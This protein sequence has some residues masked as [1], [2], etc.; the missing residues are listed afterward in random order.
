M[1]I[2]LLGATGAMGQALYPILNVRNHQ[3]FVTT[4]QK[5]P[6]FENVHFLEG[7]AFDLNF[8]KPLL[9][10]NKWDAVVDFM[11]YGSDDFKNRVSMFLENTAHYFFLSS[12][13]VYADVPDGII[14]DSP[15][16]LDASNDADFLKTDEY[17]LAKARSENV[18]KNSARQ[19]FTIIR[20]YITFSPY[21]LQL[22]ILEKESWLYRAMQGRT[23]I[24]CQDF[25]N[26]TTTMT[27][28]EIVAKIIAYLIE[29]SEKSIGQTFH[30][31][32]ENHATWQEILGIYQE[33][34][35]KNGV[36][37]KT[38][39]LALADFL[40]LHPWNRYQI[41]YD[42]MFCRAF[43][44]PKLFEVLDEEHRALLQ[45]PSLKKDLENALSLFLK[46]PRFLYT[47]WG[48]EGKKDHITSQLAKRKEFPNTNAYKS[49][50]KARFPLLQFCANKKHA[51]F[52]RLKHFSKG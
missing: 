14:E 41:L 29:H 28:G 11:V 25:L 38:K 16:L 5:R 46:N 12:A 26:K 27:S 4:R 39:N 6:S 50:L 17:A 9:T 7:N 31:A 30:I 34:L 42:R 49:Y 37:L 44:S 23:V 1:N 45:Q 20:P 24:F 2:L 8:I 52:K 32:Q 47:D 10:Q 43:K 51:F 36:I 13:R 19:N 18:L 35:A 15:R 40:A 3:V 33:I 48:A 22:G 21:R